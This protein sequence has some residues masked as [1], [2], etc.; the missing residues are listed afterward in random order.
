MSFYTFATGTLDLLG[1][2]CCFLLPS[3]M[4]EEKLNQSDYI[5]DLQYNKDVY[6]CVGCHGLY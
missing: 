5:H 2:I 4:R 3:F 1:S 6:I